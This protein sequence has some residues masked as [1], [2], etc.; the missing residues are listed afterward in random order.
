MPKFDNDIER[1]PC[2]GDFVFPETAGE[3][4][5]SVQA[6]SQERESTS[7][8]KWEEKDGECCDC[9]GADED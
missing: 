2:V 6:L 7:D 9:D 1:T 4:E 5:H 3:G 8:D